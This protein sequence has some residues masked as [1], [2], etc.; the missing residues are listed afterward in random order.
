VSN[1]SIDCLYC[2]EDQRYGDSHV[3]GCPGP[4][5]KRAMDAYWKLR[6]AYVADAMDR[7]GV[8]SICFTQQMAAAAAAK[9]EAQYPP[10]QPPPLNWTAPSDAKR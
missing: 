1:H 4:A 10:P 2:W 9:F 5:Y 3:P 7:S 8:P 6:C